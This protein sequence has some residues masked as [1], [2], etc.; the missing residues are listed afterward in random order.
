M[1][2]VPGALLQLSAPQGAERLLDLHLTVSIPTRRSRVWMGGWGRLWKAGE[3]A[4]AAGFP[5]GV[6]C[7]DSAACPLT[8]GR[9][10][11]ASNPKD[12]SQ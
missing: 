4:L 11:P 6:Y 7:T 8:G 12:V 10:A 1:T 3:L 9:A 5:G 2:V